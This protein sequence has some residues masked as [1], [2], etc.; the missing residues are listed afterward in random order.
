MR[1][2]FDAEAFAQNWIRDW[3]A[4]D[5]EA[6]MDHYD[7][8]IVFRSPLIAKILGDPS[9]E[10]RGRERLRSYFAKGLALY[11][12]LR[13]VFQRAFAGMNSVAIFYT[14]VNETPACE[15]MAFNE[16]GLVTQCMAH[17][18]RHGDTRIG[19]ERG[20]EGASDRGTAPSGLT[21]SG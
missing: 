8:S 20:D 19:P 6:I 18:A 16:R 14:S 4:H 13:F 5:L 9:G 7:E 12:D 10:I 1:E 15:V 2:K 11:P 3:N 21:E 17:Y